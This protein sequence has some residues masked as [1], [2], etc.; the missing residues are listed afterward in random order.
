M[1]S[2]SITVTDWR[3]LPGELAEKSYDFPRLTGTNSHGRAIYWQI[4]VRLID[5][6]IVK[7]PLQPAEFMPIH[8]VYFDNHPM[9]ANVH[10]WMKVASGVVGGKER[11]SSPTIITTGKN[12]G[13]RNETNVFCQALRD[14][15]GLYNK[16]LKKMVGVAG[17][18]GAAVRH[19][20]MLA[21]S[22]KADKPPVPISL[23]AI[24]DDT[25]PTCVF[26]Q[27]K[28]NGVRAVATLDVADNEMRTGTISAD[29]HVIIYSRQR[30]PYPGFEYIRAELQ[31]VLRREWEKNGRHLY[32]DGE[33]YLHGASLQDISGLAR[34]SK[35]S[36]HVTA[37]E[38]QTVV[39][40]NNKEEA[41]EPPQ[42][43]NVAMNYMIYD[44]FDPAAPELNFSA[45]YEI[46]AAMFAEWNDSGEKPYFVHAKLAETKTVCSMEEASV[47]Y[48]KYLA[49]GYEGAMLRLDQPYKY[50]HNG[51]HSARLLKMKPT[52]DEEYRVVGWETGER[53]KAADLLMLI[54]EVVGRDGQTRQFA[55]TPAAT[56]DERRRLA[57][58]MSTVDASGRTYFDRE[59]AGQMV[60]VY[61]DELSDD[62]VPQ[63]GRTK[64]ERLGKEIIK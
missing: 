42:Q 40:A 39:A 27:R 51:H 57:A 9:P 33:I 32:L 23:P 22:L 10:A 35:Q 13:R 52:H 24:T 38:M 46:M 5:T 20:P 11:T 25:A 50:S 16:Q 3:S 36:H 1:A 61:F 56:E 34:R 49:E 31:P 14:A 53:G 44:C 48:S 43:Q 12:I 55:V 8:D 58:L 29:T 15:L 7:T 60:R 21:Q 18:D 26:I 28:Y 54:C 4:T 62:D 19:P 63:R 47:E 41:A 6:N 45:R 64:L 30:H 2:T 37:A 17:E 59:W